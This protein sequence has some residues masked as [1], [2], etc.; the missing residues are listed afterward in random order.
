[1]KYSDA[2]LMKVNDS[3]FKNGQGMLA[4]SGMLFIPIFTEQS[5]SVY[6]IDVY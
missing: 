3:D 6:D 5:I 2:W 4:S 1:M